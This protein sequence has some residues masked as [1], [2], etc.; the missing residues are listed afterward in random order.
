MYSVSREQAL[1]VFAT[2]RAGAA[3]APPPAVNR[4][5][6]LAEIHKADKTPAYLYRSL[7][8]KEFRTER[9]TNGLSFGPDG[10]T[11]TTVDISA[12][13]ELKLNVWNVETGKLARTI[14]SPKQTACVAFS[15]DGKRHGVAAP[16]T[17]VPPNPDPWKPPFSV[18]IFDTVRNEAAL[19]M[20]IAGRVACMAF[21]P[22][23]KRFAAGFA[24][25]SMQV[26]TLPRGELQATLKTFDTH[27]VQNQTIWIEFS[28]DGKQ[29][30]SYCRGKLCSWDLETQQITASTKIATA[31][32]F[33]FSQDGRVLIIRDEKVRF[34]DAR[35]F[36]RL[37]SF[38][39][40]PTGPLLLSSD[41]KILVTAHYE[42]RSIRVSSAASGK[43]LV[44]IPCDANV[45]HLVFA[46]DGK[47]LAASQLDYATTKSIIGLWTIYPRDQPGV[48]ANRAPAAPNV[49]STKPVPGTWQVAHVRPLPWTSGKPSVKTILAAGC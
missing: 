46:P 20:T 28:P 26:W 32:P 17:V 24:D 14:E 10:K 41:G 5:P 13:Q 6:S 3:S 48:D 34:L 25:G 18:S 15:P 21:S 27:E 42:P 4:P 31:P 43:L 44:Q 12:E 23:G 29:F 11:L 9:F 39:L 37:H 40:G 49:K 45:Q 30:V 2:S 8:V 38:D 22:D 47:T 16:E 36:E 19:Q 1:V 7:P 33:L 35:T